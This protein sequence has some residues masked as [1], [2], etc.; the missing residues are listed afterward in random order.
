MLTTLKDL[1]IGYVKVSNVGTILNHNSTFNKIFGYNP[2][3]NIIGT[4]TL[5]Y[6]LNSEDRNKFREK[7]YKNG[8]VRKYITPLKKLDGEKIFIQMSIKLNKNSE[9]EFISS[10]GTFADI[11]ERIKTEQKL[12]KSEKNYR[13]IIN[14]ARDGILIIG[15]DGKFKF[16][17]LQLSN[18]LGG[19][20]IN[21]K[22]N[23]FEFVHPDDKNYLIKLFSKGIREKSALNE[24][25]EF[26]A[27]HKDGHYIWLSSSI[28]NY[29][30]DEGNMTGFISLLRD[31]SEKKIAE[32]KL[33]ETE[34][35]FR[36]IAE[37]SLMGI[38]IIQDDLIKYANPR[39][40]EINGY[41]LEEMLNW[42]PKEFYKT[43]ATE[44]LD[45]A[46]EQ[47]KKKQLG[48]P[49]TI[50]H[51]TVQ[52]IKKSGKKIWIESF[53]KTIDFNGRPAILAT[54]FD[55]NDKIKA[56]QKLKESEEKYRLITENSNDLISVLDDR[57]QYKFVNRAY[58]LLGYST[59]EIYNSQATDFIHPD[60]IKRAVKAF[61]KGLVKGTGSEELRV[62]HKDGRFSWF[63]VK[64]KTFTNLNGETN[65]LLISRDIT[66]R[67]KVEQKL[68]ES[69]KKFRT[70]VENS[71]DFM[72]FI[73]RDGTIFDVNRLDKGFT[74]EMVIGQSIFNEYFYENEDMTEIARIAISDLMETG[75]INRYESSQ[76]APDGSLSFYEN[77]VSPFGYDNEN[78]IISFQLTVHDITER[79]EKEKEIFDLA[80]FPSEDPYPILRVNR[81]GI[82]YINEA[83]QKLL[84]VVVTDQ[85]PEI[86]QESVKN[87]YES[88]QISESEV[89]IDNRVYSFTITPIKDAEYVNIYG[90][91]I[92]ERKH[93]EENLKEVNKLKSEFL[94]RAPH[95]LKTPLISI[96]GFS[97]LILALYRE[98]LNPD[99]LS[100]LGEIN[101]GCER[102]QSI[103]NDLIYTSRLESSELK[104]KFER[105]DLT[106]L[107]NYCVDELSSI[108]TKRKHSIKID[109]PN[110]LIA[111][112]EKEE[113][114]VVITNILSNA[115]KY[116]P[117]K[118]CIEIK[119][120]T[121]EDSIVVSIKDNGI[122]FTKE[123]KDRIFQ[124]FG[125]IERYGQGLF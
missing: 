70:A 55:I 84:N 47:V 87:S 94:R 122:G 4:K 16:I 119:T 120:E 101:H 114:H 75:K 32:Q 96:K 50:P 41:S 48:L 76:I 71:P 113:I 66:E 102:L 124:Q 54:N 73:K 39:M 17:S 42:Q 82:M 64:G 107:I 118:G 104:P 125:K 78:R 24:E 53:S 57:L 91:D 8:I 93:I 100:K 26:R 89:E 99:I 116:T 117:P 3:E 43:I 98:E 35:K 19:R 110:S 36:N 77:I 108:A 28:K 106:F 59:E 111:R 30:D 38:S 21:L 83:G 88:S 12:K 90:M 7:L 31:V 85:I 52:L 33:K 13:T 40:A 92:T 44:S 67:K 45:F 80:Q 51:N 103:I 11:S 29:Y 22:T 56:E 115:I 58:E 105:E 79:K 97:D 61:R 112:F 74:R 63:E 109:L 49:G 95:E 121:L 72:L 2:K 46:A 86:F 5:D 34:E 60:D 81:N 65:A 69:E 9:G 20:D 37:Q 10:E 62:K 6:W 123:E 23:I 25:V 14:N 27:Q 68:K 15:L 1:D 18:M